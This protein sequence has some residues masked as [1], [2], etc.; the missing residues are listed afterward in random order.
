MV[1]TPK[2]TRSV[3]TGSYFCVISFNKIYSYRRTYCVV[4]TVFDTPNGPKTETK[5][6]KYFLGETNQTEKTLRTKKILDPSLRVCAI[7]CM[8]LKHT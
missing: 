2:Q 6:K 5:E 4:L 8:K 7:Q 1:L 3:L